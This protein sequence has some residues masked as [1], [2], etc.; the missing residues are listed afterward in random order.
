MTDQQFTSLAR[1]F[2][3][4]YANTLNR[5]DL[6]RAETLVR[7]AL[8]SGAG[9]KGIKLL[10]VDAAQKIHDIHSPSQ[11][12]ARYIAA[13]ELLM[14]VDKIQSAKKPSLQTIVE[15]NLP[16]FVSIEQPDVVFGDVIGQNHAKKEIRRV[17]VDPFTNIC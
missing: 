15:E 10:Y 12:D 14:L 3:T 5:A 4:S 8:A 6:E 13:K 7:R 2:F 16:P 1:N 11:G 9:V 17:V